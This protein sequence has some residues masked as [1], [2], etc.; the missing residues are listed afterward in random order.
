MQAGRKEGE[1]NN[2]NNNNIDDSSISII[3]IFIRINDFNIN[4]RKFIDY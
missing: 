1:N 3:E 2:N 4:K